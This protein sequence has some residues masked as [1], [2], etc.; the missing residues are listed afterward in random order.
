MKCDD[1]GRPVGAAFMLRP[2]ESY[3]SVNWLECT[4]PSSR[5]EQLEIVRKHLTDKGR[6]LTANG[7]LAVLHLKTV[8]DFIE[9]E[10]PDSRRITAHHEPELPHD[11]SHS[12]IYGYNAHDG[13][14]GDL[15]AEVVHEHYAARS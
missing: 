3:L 2:K 11:P 12:G 4:G 14:I 6:K 10:T 5:K 15:I 8:F 9:T 13:L 7:R 1:A